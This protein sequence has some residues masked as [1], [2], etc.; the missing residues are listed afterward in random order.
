MLSLI[1]F[2]LKKMLL[3]RVSLLTSTGVALLM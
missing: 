2:E 3:R 1:G